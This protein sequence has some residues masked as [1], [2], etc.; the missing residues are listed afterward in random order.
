MGSLS[1]SAS[2]IAAAFALLL[3][4]SHAAKAESVGR[5]LEQC[6]QAPIGLNNQVTACV[7]VVHAG[8]VLGLTVC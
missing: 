4:Q 3:L 6:G 7:F 2:T 5:C 1:I 8:S